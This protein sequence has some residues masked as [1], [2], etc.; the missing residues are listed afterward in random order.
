MVRRIQANA[1]TTDSHR[2]ALG[3]TVPDRL[4]TPV[5]PPTTRPLVKVDFSK[6]LHHR[7]AFADE[8]TPTRRAK[9]KGI[10]GAEVWVNI[11]APDDPPP[12]PVSPADPSELRFL[13]LSTRTP[14]V[15]EYGGEDAGE[16]AHYMLRWLSSRGEP[17]PWSETASA[18][19]G[20]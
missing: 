18:T 4:P 17:G 6:R 8:K 5:G 10:L 9:P 14:A 2:A 16:T 1:K 20:A 3:I 15:A 19:I 7:I 13:L 12:T 11:S